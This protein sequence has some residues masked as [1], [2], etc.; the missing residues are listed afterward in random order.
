MI[1]K[2]EIVDQDIKI[3]I[4]STLCMSKQTEQSVSMLKRNR[5]DTK[6]VKKTQ[7]DLVEMKNILEDI[8]N[9]LDTEKES[10]GKA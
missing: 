5:Q 8:N 1:Q 9:R 3:T 2:V 6:E 10:T 4:I 7:I